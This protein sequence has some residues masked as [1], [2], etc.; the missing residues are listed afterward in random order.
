MLVAFVCI[1][2]LQVLIY[3][4]TAAKKVSK[5]IGQ[6]WCYN[7]FKDPVLLITNEKTQMYF[8]TSKSL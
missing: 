7:K 8:S 3:L 5:K 6:T 1:N 2:G 4:A